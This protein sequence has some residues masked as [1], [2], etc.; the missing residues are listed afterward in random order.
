MWPVQPDQLQPVALEHPAHRL[1]GVR[2]TLRPV[3]GQREPELL[4]LVRGGDELVGVRL[5]ADRHPDHHRL[6]DT[7]V[8][9]HLVQPGDLEERVQHDGADPGR[10]ALFEFRHG[11]VV[12]VHGDALGR[13]PGPQRDG[14]LAAAAHVQGE[15]LGGDPPGHLGAQERLRR[16]VHRARLAV[17]LGELPAAG[18]EVGLVQHEQR[19]A[20]ARGQLPD[21]H[22]GDLHRAVCRTP[23]GVARPHVRRQRVQ[24][25]RGC[26]RDA[27]GVGRDVQVGVPGSGG[28]RSHIR[29]GALTPSRPRPS[30]MTR[31]AAAPSATLA[32]CCS[33]VGSSPLGRAG[34]CRS[35]S[36]TRPA[37]RSR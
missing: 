19:R 2:V 18:T 17:G 15:P 31:R 7:P 21:V 5:H 37:S 4:V 26:R 34:Q 14:Q 33:D 25:F 28:V 16:V 13:E 10:H 32:R 6:P 24:F 35:N 23:A 30:A 36:A 9:G 11:L 12:A 29:S 27:G 8:A 22:A 1:G 3:R 20:V